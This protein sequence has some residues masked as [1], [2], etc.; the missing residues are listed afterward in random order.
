MKSN[1]TVLMYHAVADDRGDC[2]GADPHYGVS[3]HSFIGNLRS[4][5]EIG[6]RCFSVLRLL[7]E[8]AA[9][10]NAVALTFDDGH[11]S[12]LAA[13]ELIAESGG[14][15]D[16]FVNPSTVGTPNYLTWADLRTMA[17]WGM[18]IQSHGF[19]HRFFDEMTAQEAQSEL[20][21]SK[22][23]IENH[24]GRPVTVFA[25][26]GGRLSRKTAKTALDCGY[27]AICSS[28]VGL[29]SA[30]E[31]EVWDIPRLAVLQSTTPDQFSRWIRQEPM[32][33]L[34]RRARYVL[35]RGAKQL[36]GNQGYERLRQGLLR[37]P[38]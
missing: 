36:L 10:A 38:G 33:M 1:I 5:A 24:V 18:S 15:A 31:A 29:W 6:K 8:P 14:S 16:F 27:R 37:T 23:S 30:R 21:D 26:P 7:T 9:T 28:R 22:L 2:P 35:L 17:D 11:A 4:I 3:R 34:G 25:P 13:A 19:H 12:N 32:E 20:R